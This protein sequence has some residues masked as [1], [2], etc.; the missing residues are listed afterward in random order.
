M[1]ARV[2]RQRLALPSPCTH[3]TRR[4][5]FRSAALCLVPDS[6]GLAAGLLSF[7]CPLSVCGFSAQEERAQQ[8]HTDTA[9]SSLEKRRK[10][11][12]PRRGFCFP[13]KKN[14]QVPIESTATLNNAQHPLW[15]VSGHQEHQVC[16]IFEPCDLKVAKLSTGQYVVIASED[17]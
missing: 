5:P 14:N 2:Q 9:M 8:P 10:P 1:A 13:L 17:A 15:A 12:G 3:N 4:A 11:L 16:V 7:R 6:R